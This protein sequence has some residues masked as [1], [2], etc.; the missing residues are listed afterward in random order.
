RRLPLPAFASYADATGRYIA[1]ATAR[2][3]AGVGVDESDREL[4][5]PKAERFEP[6]ISILS[7]ILGGAVRTGSAERGTRVTRRRMVGG[8]RLLHWR[9]P[10][11]QMGDPA[12]I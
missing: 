3:R 1:F 11:A 5:A 6:G 9:L 12:G 10:D 7:R 4:A 8:C 2:K